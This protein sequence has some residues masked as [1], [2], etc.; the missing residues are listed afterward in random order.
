MQKRNQ[1]HIFF[2]VF[3]L[4]VL[5]IDFKNSWYRLVKE[6]DTLWS[7]SARVLSSMNQTDKWRFYI[8]FSRIKDNVKKLFL[9][10]ILCVKFGTSPLDLE[11]HFRGKTMTFLLWKTSSLGISE[12]TICLIYGHLIRKRPLIDVFP[13]VVNNPLLITISAQTW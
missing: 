8:V 10:K 12:V 13:V 4:Y 1:W 7:C 11:H 6:W 3:F 5:S 2:F 9:K